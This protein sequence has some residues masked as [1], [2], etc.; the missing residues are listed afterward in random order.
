MDDGIRTPQALRV[1]D[2]P[3]R[4]FHWLLV[5]A[6]TTAIA[7]GLAGGNWM[8]VHGKAGLAIAGLVAFRL[9]WGF[10][11]NRYARFTNFAPTPRVL[12]TYLRGE[13]QGHGHNP[14]GALSV[15]VLLILL[16]T[17]VGTGL[18]GN[19]EIAF[20]GPLAGLV[21]ESLS[22]RLTGLHH[23]LA[24]ALYLLLGLHVVAILF[25]T[26]VKKD[27]LVKPMLTGYKETIQETPHP[28]PAKVGWASLVFAL[29]TALGTLYVASGA[30][31]QAETPSATPSR[32]GT[33]SSQP[34]W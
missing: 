29:A 10:V 11:G 28:T 32:S 30:P 4:L 21:S 13:W 20:T 26:V 19:D 16:S 5:A 9:V 22:L 2:L 8:A 24:I 14:L 7:S 6:V 3:T 12:K 31:L 34:S 1:W 23:Q 15:L 27:N 17:Q 33:D 18:F 25:H